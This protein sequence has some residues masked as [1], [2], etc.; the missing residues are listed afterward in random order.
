V[1][2]VSAQNTTVQFVGVYRPI[3]WNSSKMAITRAERFKSTCPFGFF[4][5]S[6]GSML[7]TKPELK[8]DLSLGTLP[9][10][11]HYFSPIIISKNGKNEHWH[12]WCLRIST[13]ADVYVRYIQYR[14][15]P[16]QYLGVDT[17][18]ANLYVQTGG[19]LVL[20]RN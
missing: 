10:S 18:T 20:F 19:K 16:C 4:H 6:L 14:W 13:N 5:T 1:S 17:D 15:R 12:S 3:A 2:T 9:S 8:N 7:C 11:V